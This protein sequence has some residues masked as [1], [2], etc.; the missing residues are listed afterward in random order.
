MEKNPE[1]FPKNMSPFT[2]G[3]PFLAKLHEIDC[4][5]RKFDNVL[6]GNPEVYNTVECDMG[7]KGVL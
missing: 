4:D 7:R 1:M 3:D 5:I 6:G 2:A